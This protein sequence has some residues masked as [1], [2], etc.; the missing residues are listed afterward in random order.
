VPAVTMVYVG[1]GPEVHVYDIASGVRVYVDTVLPGG[2][3]HGFRWA[4]AEPLV[5]AADHAVRPPQYLL[6]KKEDALSW[7]TGCEAG[8]CSAGAH[9]VAIRTSAFGPI[10][11]AAVGDCCLRCQPSGAV[12]TAAVSR[13]GVFPIVAAFPWFS[14]T[15]A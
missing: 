6:K 7:A 9:V 10:A 12:R 2:V 8:Q 5:R 14:V 11:L 1:C 15:S 3:V 13:R 4:G